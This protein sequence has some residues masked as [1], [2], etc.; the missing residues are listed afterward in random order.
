MTYLL[1][2]LPCL[3]PHSS[4]LLSLDALVSTFCL[5]VCRTFTF[6]SVVNN[7]IV[8]KGGWKGTEPH[9]DALAYPST[10]CSK[11]QNN[12][13]ADTDTVRCTRCTAQLTHACLNQ[14]ASKNKSVFLCVY[15][16]STSCVTHRVRSSCEFKT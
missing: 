10:H 2:L 15:S 1:S 7:C 8:T 11:M 5:F 16:T 4:L 13:P 6:P 3:S 12:T 9:L 14:V